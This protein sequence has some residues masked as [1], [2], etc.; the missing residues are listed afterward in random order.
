MWMPNDI[1][2]ETEHRLARDILYNS[3]TIISG[4]PGI[5]KSYCFDNVKDI[6]ISDSDS[7]KF[8]KANFPQNY[9]EHIK[10]LT[11]EYALVSSHATVRDALT[12]EKIPFILVYPDISLKDE[13]I[14]RYKARGSSAVFIEL[15]NNNWAGWITELENQKVSFISNFNPINIFMTFLKLK[16][17]EKKKN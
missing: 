1:E 6:D 13:Y 2:I 16:Q 12:Q 7:S 17:Y 10:N 8:D 11:N 3:K 4:F 5:G 9:I 14:E 15:V